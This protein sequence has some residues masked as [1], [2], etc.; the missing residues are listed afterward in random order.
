[1][2]LVLVEVRRKMSGVGEGAEAVGFETEDEA[3]DESVL[4][5]VVQAA[6]GTGEDVGWD[7]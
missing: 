7:R 4:Q 5:A 3:G 1:M 6:I 2:K